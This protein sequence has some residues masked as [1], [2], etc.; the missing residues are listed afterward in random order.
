M[1]FGGYY[2]QNSKKNLFIGSNSNQ[3]RIIDGLRIIGLENSFLRKKIYSFDIVKKPKPNPINIATPKT[4]KI[5][6]KTEILTSN[7]LV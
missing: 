3:D 1:R 7:K 4:I 2:I 5:C 6:I